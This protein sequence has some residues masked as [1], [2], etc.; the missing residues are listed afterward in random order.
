[1]E[2]INI[3]NNEFDV[4]EFICEK[5]LSINISVEK[6]IYFPGDEMKG[7]V[8]IQGKGTLTNPLF[9]YSLVKVSISQIYY[10]EY[11]VETKFIDRLES[12]GYE[13]IEL[14]DYSDV[15]KYFK[16]KL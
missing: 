2:I 14:K 3:N 16:N 8:Y 5:K 6:N 11:D 7:F 13:Y 9:I 4:K 12:I 15:L 1:M 10:Y